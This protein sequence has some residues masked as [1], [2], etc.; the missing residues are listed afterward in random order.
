MTRT[1]IA[2][3]LT[4]LFLLAAGPAFAQADDSEQPTPESQDTTEYPDDAA[5]P[6][7]EPAPA[8]PM[9]EAEPTPEVGAGPSTEPAPA[10]PAPET[11]PT[12]SPESTPDVGTGPAETQPSAETSPTPA[13]T[14][15]RSA[16]EP[17]DAP[18]GGEYVVKEGDTLSEI[19][20]EVTGNQANWQQIA[21]ENGIDDPTQLQVGQRL[22]MPASLG[23]ASERLSSDEASA[24]ANP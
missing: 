11:Q 8:E 2:S 19:A 7:A 5:A 12:P 4:A 16:S 10:E 14:A 20:K 9:P 24:P 22:R 15:P 21:Q 6:S 17:T 13:E 23:D 3:T 1:K 18:A